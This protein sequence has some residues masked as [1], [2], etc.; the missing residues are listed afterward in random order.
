M[1]DR[2]TCRLSFSDRLPRTRSRALREPTTISRVPSSRVPG[3]KSRTW[4]LELW[5]L[6][7]SQGSVLDLDL[8]RFD[9]VAD[10][11]VVEAGD[12]HAALEA[13]ADLLHVVLE[14]LQA[15]EADHPVALREDHDALADY[16]HPG[17]PLDHPA[18][19]VAPG[20]RPDLR[21]PERLPDD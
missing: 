12:L 6:E 10:F 7:L 1:T 2:T 9:H 8:V 17:R 18:R 20:D 11:H 3:S 16:P 21:D 4:N 5:N 13:L 14:P 19:D 15:V